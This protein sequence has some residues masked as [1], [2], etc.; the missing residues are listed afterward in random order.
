MTPD[1]TTT[2]EYR[3]EPRDRGDD[4][5]MFIRFYDW[6]EAVA[7]RNQVLPGRKIYARWVQPNGGGSA[8]AEVVEA[9]EAQHG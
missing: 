1:T 3:F 5:A 7:H 9:K 6:D 8:W 4:A 2:R